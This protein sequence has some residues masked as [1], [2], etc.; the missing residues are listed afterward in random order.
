M[1]TL[2]LICIVALLGS[3]ASPKTATSYESEMW[4]FTLRVNDSIVK[5]RI[6][7]EEYKCYLDSLKKSYFLNV[8][9]SN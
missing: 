3:C 7:S 1:R 6:S 8:Y 5:K 9:P 2:I 4:F